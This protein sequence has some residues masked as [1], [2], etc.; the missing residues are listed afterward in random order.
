MSDYQ[1]QRKIYNM[2]FEAY[3]GLEVSAQS[4]SLGRLFKFQSM[5]NMPLSEM[6]AEFQKSIFGFFASRIITW[7]VTHPELDADEEES[8]VCSVCGMAAGAPLPTT[9]ES[10]FCLPL[11]FIMDIIKGW[12]TT[13]MRVS[14]PKD[15]SSNNGGNNT[16]EEMMKRLGEMQNPRTS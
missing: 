4:A 7:N 9:Q 16:L 6:S 2:Q 5:S 1:P 3:P 15:E 13:L 10:M 8:G 11:E 14:D 12:M